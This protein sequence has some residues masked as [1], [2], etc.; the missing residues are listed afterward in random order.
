MTTV[1]EKKRDPRGFPLEGVNPENS[2]G[3][4]KRQVQLLDRNDFFAMSLH[5]N[6]NP[7]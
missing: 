4:R 3:E 7:T 5:F 2:L 6:P 1:T